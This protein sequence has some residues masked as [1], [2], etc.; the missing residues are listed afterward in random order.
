M[1]EKIL[2]ITFIAQLVL[3]LTWTMENH[4]FTNS[5]PYTVWNPWIAFPCCSKS[6]LRRET[7]PKPMLNVRI[8]WLAP[9]QRN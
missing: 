4:L 8:S 9:F 6:R 5:D 2:T 3:A 1:V 7:P